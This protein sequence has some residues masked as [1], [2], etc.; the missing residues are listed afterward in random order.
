MYVHGSVLR[1]VYASF[2]NRS[3]QDVRVH[4]AGDA[5]I[6]PVL[7]DGHD[8]ACDGARPL[9]VQHALDEVARRARARVERAIQQ[10]GR[11]RLEV[12]TQADRHQDVYPCR[13]WVWPHERGGLEVSALRASMPAARGGEC[14]S[15]GPRVGRH[16]EARVERQAQARADEAC[17]PMTRRGVRQRPPTRAV[18]PSVCVERGTD[19]C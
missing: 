13:G 14:T 9:E 10:E 4:A 17:R 5:C 7:V 1:S 6:Q 19:R 8:G 12:A 16:S 3:R 2:F 15:A 11:V 18:D